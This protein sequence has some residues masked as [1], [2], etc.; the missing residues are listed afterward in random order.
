MFDVGKRSQ[1][2]INW[3]REAIDGN[4]ARTPFHPGVERL[5]PQLCPGLR[6]DLPRQ[7]QASLPEGATAK[8]Q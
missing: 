5:S 2:L 7:M 4:A 3:V 6:G 8:Q 1:S